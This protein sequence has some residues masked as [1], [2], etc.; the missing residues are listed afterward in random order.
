MILNRLIDF[1]RLCKEI[2][3]VK[4]IHGDKSN[5]SLSIYAPVKNGVGRTEII[6]FNDD[7]FDFYNLIKKTCWIDIKLSTKNIER[8]N[9]FL[10]ILE[11]K[12]PNI[13]KDYK[14]IFKDNKVKIQA[15]SEFDKKLKTLKLK[16]FTVN[17]NAK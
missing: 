3:Y 10:N 8:I 13:H 15:F 17:N 14:L 11:N 6:A 1:Y 16:L 9:I 12:Y 5:G 4:L 2:G 7:E